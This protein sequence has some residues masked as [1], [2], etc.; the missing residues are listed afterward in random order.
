MTK[1]TSTRRSKSNQEPVTKQGKNKNGKSIPSSGT[2]FN[3]LNGNSGVPVCRL[4]LT[5]TQYLSDY[6][7]LKEQSR[8]AFDRARQNISRDKMEDCIKLAKKEEA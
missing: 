8:D 3:A 5:L 2:P 6:L 7:L 1:S 4:P